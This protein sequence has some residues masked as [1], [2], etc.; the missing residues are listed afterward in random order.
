M[1]L[2]FY[3]EIQGL[4]LLGTLPNSWETFR[5]SLS[6]FAPNGIISMDLAKSS[7]L[8]EEL[9]RKSR[10]S[11]SYSVVLITESRRRHQSRGTSNHETSCGKSQRGSNIFPNDV[12][13]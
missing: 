5:T 10:G 7:M 3:E 11:S 8:N 4:W 1:N 6:N 2:N 13:I 12:R 9:R